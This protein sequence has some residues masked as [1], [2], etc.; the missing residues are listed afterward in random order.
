MSYHDC[1]IPTDF[2]AK[3]AALN[4]EQLNALANDF[5]RLTMEYSSEEEI[6]IR[7]L[8]IERRISCLD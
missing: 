4:D 8:A 6:Y 5:V 3:M 1:E 2:R 7:R